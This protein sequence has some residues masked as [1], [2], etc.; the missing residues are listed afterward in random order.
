MQGS[1]HDGDPVRQAGQAETCGGGLVEPAAV[2]ADLDGQVPVR[3]LGLASLADRMAIVD[4]A[5]R[6]DSSPGRGTTLRA[7]VPLTAAGA[8]DG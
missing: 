7:E 2:V 6:I 4:G 5:L 1:V 8:G 3:G